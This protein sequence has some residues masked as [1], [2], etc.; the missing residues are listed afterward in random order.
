MGIKKSRILFLLIFSFAFALMLASAG[1]AIIFNEIMY[2]PTDSL[3]GLYG[4]WIELYNPSGTDVNISG[5][6]IADPSNHLIT[7]GNLI[8]PASGYLVIV[9]TA[10]FD[11]FSSYYNATGFGKAGF[12][13]NNGGEEIQ[14]IDSNGSLVDSVTYSTSWGGDG[15]NYSI[16]YNGTEWCEGVT[17]VGGVNSCAVQEQNE[18]QENQTVQTCKNVTIEITDYPESI[19]FGVSD[20]VEV[21]FNSTCY[22][23]S[24]VKFLVY[25]SSNKVVSYENG[26]K[27]KIYSDCQNGTL[28]E[29]L[30]NKTY[31]WK[32]PFFTYPNCDEDY[33]E[34]NYTLSLRVC[35]PS[36]DK[37]DEKDF[38][39]EF[40]GEN[41]TVCSV[42]TVEVEEVIEEEYSEE[43]ETVKDVKTES[44]NEKVV[45]ESKGDKNLSISIYLLG[46]LLVLLV[47][48]L[49]LNKHNI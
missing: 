40:S 1:Q 31:E 29:D 16:Q 21:N 43:E 12:G 41:S 17:T 7:E 25:G 49:L 34:D 42:E 3:G 28:F 46:T 45:L 11:N 26:T 6:K 14:L 15:N 23:W 36:W 2:N 24:S 18:T 38:I 10:F 39:V 19:K 47:A 9:K 4:E 27:I 37:F 33:D 5:W 8:V 13:L 20:E 32:I 22:N 44:K 30:E 48:Y 35:N